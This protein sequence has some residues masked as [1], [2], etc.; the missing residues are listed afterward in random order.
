GNPQMDLHDQGV[1]DSGCSRHVTG[2]MSYLTGYKEIDRGY[3]AF[4][5]NPKRRENH[6]KV[7]NGIGVNAGDS[8]VTAV[9]HNLLLLVLMLLGINLQL[10]GKVNAARHKLTTAGES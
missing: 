2:N 7:W 1:I 3:V 9:R 10:L 4:R 8:K 6:R 5:G